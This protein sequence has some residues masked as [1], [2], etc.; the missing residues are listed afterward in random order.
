M[1]KELCKQR[2][3]PP[4]WADKSVNWEARRAEILR[5]LCEE[6][7]GVMPVHDSIHWDILSEKPF[8]AGKAI[9]RKV[10]LTVRFGEEE[11]S[12]PIYA[13]I[14]TR[15][16]K[17]P[18]FVHINFRENV[19]D[20]YMPSE[21]IC[22]RGF[23]VLSFCYHSVTVDEVNPGGANY[24]QGL[25]SLLFK[26]R[27]RADNACG[28]I[29]M[30]AW[31]ASR[32]LDYA[33]TLDSLDCHQAAVV[34]HSRLGKTALLAGALDSRFACAISNDSGCSG[35]AISRGKAGESVKY[36]TTAFPHWFCRNYRKYAD[37]ESELPFDQHFLIA[38]QAPRLVYVASAVED[39]WSDPDS[40]YLSCFAA[41]EVWQR[42]GKKGFICPDRL[43]RAGEKFHEGDIG[44]HVR[45]GSHY[46]S[47]E[48]WNHFMDFLETKR[49]KEESPAV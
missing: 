24:T 12:F 43:P 47:R 11:F 1:L 25:N 13:S 37:H 27:E 22:D 30:W 7:Y 20:R 39:E 49:Q 21:E 5:L 16:G 10:L 18:F 36:I 40:E 33:M 4:V 34:G 46:F 35:A 3:L 38:A 6:E 45:Y 48:D 23:A 9:L 28:K 2:A 41:S 8:C 17:H 32:V 26:H 31:G 44:Y 42:L 14:P 15:A 29:A 19:P